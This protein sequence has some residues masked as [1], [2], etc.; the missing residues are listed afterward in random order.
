MDEF[1][2]VSR[3]QKVLQAHLLQEEVKENLGP[4]Q[5]ARTFQDVKVK[6]LSPGIWVPR[7][8]NLIGN[9]P[10]IDIT[11]I[12]HVVDNYASAEEAQETNFDSE[13]SEALG[14][15]PVRIV[16]KCDFMNPGFSSKDRLL[17]N[18]LR[19]A[20]KEGLLQSKMTVISILYSEKDDTGQAAAM[21][22]AMQSFPCI[23]LAPSHLEESAPNK[24]Q[25][26]KAYGAE[27]KFCE[28][29]TREGSG[30]S[31]SEQ[32]KLVA[33][34]MVK[35]D[36]KSYYF[37]DK[38]GIKNTK[39]LQESYAEELVPEVLAQVPSMTHFICFEAGDAV[40]KLLKKHNVSCE[41]VPTEDKKLNMKEAVEMS[42]L[43]AKNFGLLVGT[44][45]GYNVYRA[46]EKARTINSGVICTVLSDV[47]L[48]FLKTIFSKPSTSKKDYK[49]PIVPRS[50]KRIGEAFQLK[51]LIG[52]TPLV[53]LSHLVD[54]KHGKFVE[55]Y[56]KVEFFNPGFSI[57]DRIISNILGKAVREGRLTPG[58]TVVAASSGNTGA[59]T[60]MFCAAEGYPCII[61][62][63]PKCSKEK[64]DSIKA[65]GAKLIVSPPHAK[66]GQPDH[67]MNLARDLALT[68]PTKYFD[69]DQYD[70]LDNPEA[71]ELTLA[72]EIWEQTN[73]RV[74]TFVAGGSTGG[75]ISG[76]SRGL[77]KKN[78]NI[79][80]V[81]A[82]PVGSVLHQY[83]Q[84]R[85]TI[86]AGKFLVEGVGKGSLPGCMDIEQVDDFI[87]V[88]DQ[89]AF[90]T[91]D[92][93]ARQEGLLAGGSGGMNMFAALKWANN[94]NESGEVIVTVLPDSGIKYQSKIYNEEWLQEN[95][96]DFE[97]IELGY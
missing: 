81:F 74:T 72:K 37:C 43:L 73:G 80:A 62:T 88:K 39:S 4:Q 92:L 63:S 85:N 28:I 44:K 60:A 8:H 59:A 83:I 20:Q 97:K 9:T 17:W 91:C 7:F 36:A 76:T 54:N 89:E 16:A 10:V 64:M 1:C 93:L 33:H 96:V 68:D 3:H 57:K 30:K 46:V 71:H 11:N 78:S 56:A 26:I 50:L 87:L 86:K 69:V 51:D 2:K 25:T 29:E 24:L 19:N 42:R 67:Y 18:T 35:A 58:M 79:K 66:E 38:Y 61:T 77:K 65:Y 27:I 41:F 21:V 55:L 6:N 31:S 15:K 94:V 53:N 14:S 23:I 84:K 82:D 13:N 52:N 12:L 34:D 47:G 32:L 70:N 5:I 40:S 95:G 48:K 90:Q 22:C 49:K 75:T 45:S